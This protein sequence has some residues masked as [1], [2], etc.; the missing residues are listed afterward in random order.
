MLVRFLEGPNGAIAIADVEAAVLADELAAKRLQRSITRG[1]GGVA[2]VLRARAGGT[3]TLG[4]DA[5]LW[6]YA[7]DPAIDALPPV[8]IN[9]NPPQRDAA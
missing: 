6:R 1:L 8:D 2:V 7:V 3:F 9:L 4:G 5:S